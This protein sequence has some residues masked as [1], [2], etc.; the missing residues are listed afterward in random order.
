MLTGCQEKYCPEC[1]KF[2]LFRSNTWCGRRSRYVLA[3]V[4]RSRGQG[5]MR[6]RNDIRLALPLSRWIPTK[7]LNIGKNRK[8]RTTESSSHLACTY[9]SSML[10]FLCDR[11]LRKEMLV[12][13]RA[14]C[15]QKTR[16]HGFL[17]TEERSLYF[18]SLSWFSG[19]GYF[20]WITRQQ[21][22]ALCRPWRAIGKK[23]E[24]MAKSDKQFFP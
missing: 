14:P 1:S 24:M 3:P 19:R 10:P 17:T 8:N 6:P 7:R 23:T 12:L 2:V 16:P 22:W 11:G 9:K 21:G 20:W 15:V 13:W 4:A 5:F 18:Q